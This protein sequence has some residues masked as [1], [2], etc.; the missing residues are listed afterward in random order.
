MSLIKWQPFKEI[1]RFFEDF[2]SLP[3][4]ERMAAGDLAIDLYEKENTLVAEMSVPDVDPKD[5]TVTIDDRQLHIS[6]SR[7]DTKEHESREY[8]NKEIRRGTFTRVVQLPH[9][10]RKGDVTAKYHNGT[11]TVTM[12]KTEEATSQQ[13]EVKVE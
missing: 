13:V 12:P 8:Y 4:W 2:A 6:G 1:D 9:A 10:V 11:L 5:I 3:G 7:A